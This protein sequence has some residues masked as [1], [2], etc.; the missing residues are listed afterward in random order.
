MSFMKISS[1]QAANKIAYYNLLKFNPCFS[2][3]LLGEYQNISSNV[4][5]TCYTWEIGKA[6]ASLKS[7]L[8]GALRMSGNSFSL[9]FN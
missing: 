6:C 4:Y 7:T 5:H 1:D 9:S 2:S 3:C 8:H